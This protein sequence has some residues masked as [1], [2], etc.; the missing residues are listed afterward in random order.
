MSKPRRL[1]TLLAAVALATPAAALAAVTD[2]AGDFLPTYTGPQAGDLDI[3][4]AGAL[5]GAADVTL[6][7][8]LN[9]SVGTTA[10]A[11]V[12]FGVNRGAGTPGLLQSTM[13]MIG[14]HAAHDAVV[15][16]RPDLTGTVVLIGAGPPVFTNLAPGAISVAG[17]TIQGVIPLSLLPSTG[18]AVADYRYTAWTRSA[19]GSNAFVADFAPDDS[20]FRA[21]VPEPATWGLMILGFGASG[22]LLRRRRAAFG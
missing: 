20:T 17:D 21:A 16:L 8:V 18:F 6:T 4:E 14:A 15:L 11:F 1:V 3:L 19:P 2:A 9:G 7:T 22:S 5:L 10:G 12:A 13:P